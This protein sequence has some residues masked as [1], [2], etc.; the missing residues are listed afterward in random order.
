MALHVFSFLPADARARAAVICRA[1]R[2]AVAEPSL[3]TRLDLSIA[4]G[5]KHPVSDAVLRGA[6]ALARG[7]LEVLDLSCRGPTRRARLKVVVANAGSLL[8]LSCCFDDG[9]VLGFRAEE[10]L[11]RAA[12]QL[13]LFHAH[14][15][16]SVADA[17]SMLRNDAPFGA[18][19]LR[20]LY[21]KADAV[22]DE[23]DEATVLELAAAMPRHASLTKLIVIDVPLGTPAALDAV[24]AAALA[25]RLHGLVLRRC[26]LS[27]ASVPALSR[28]I[29][30]GALTSVEI[31]NDS[32]QLLDAPAAVQL[33][34]AIAAS[35]TVTSV[36]LAD[37]LFWHDAA[38]AAVVRA[39]TGHLSVR[40]L[41]LNHNNAPDKKFAGVA[42]G[43]LVAANAPALLELVLFDSEFGDAGLGPLFDALPHN[44]HLRVLDCSNTGM[45][46]EFARDCFLPAVQANTSL[47]KLAASE[48]W[49]GEEDGDAPPELLEA[50]ALVAA[51]SAAAG[52]V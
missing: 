20:V 21:V 49:G 41:A 18:L 31:D 28:V 6:A 35:R 8:E 3:W 39:L 10:Q 12:P 32:I 16:A 5:V 40:K 48:W 33:A 38:A 51:R 2:A 34:D 37:V 36:T 24:T 17:I 26:N 43:A 14:T 44:T 22:A 27:P 19:R 29:R 45:S 7:A 4:S 9:A 50:E 13:R 25:C 42:L 1:W 30:N 23:I 47:R 15:T 52:V 11:A 46:E